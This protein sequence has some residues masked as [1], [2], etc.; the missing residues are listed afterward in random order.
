MRLPGTVSKEDREKWVDTVLDLL[1]L[2]PIENLMVGTPS[3]GGMSFEQKKRVS[4]GV[5]LAANP[6]I[7]FLDE[8]TTGLDSR[9]AQVVMRGIRRVAA[10][11]RSVVCTIHQPSFPIFNMFD[12]LLLLKRGGK[13]VFF[14]QLGENC[15]NLVEFFEAAPEVSPIKPQVNPATWMLDVIGAGT[16][17]ATKNVDY[18]VYYTE[19]ALC[20]ANEVHAIE[21]SS[22]VEGLPAPP[23]VSDGEYVTSF[24]YQFLRLW[25]RQTIAYWRTPGY[26][27]TRVVISLI[28]AGIFGSA[29]PQQNYNNYLNCIARIG[30]IYITTLFVGVIG[31]QTVVPVAFD[32]RPAYY[33]ERQCNMYSAG[34][35]TIVT[36]LVEIPYLIIT[37]L[38]FVLPFF[39]IVGFNHVGNIAEKF[40][41][42]WLFVCLYIATLVTLG[43]MCVAVSP[44][45]QISNVIASVTSVF[46]SMFSG[47]MIQPQNIPQFWTFVYWLNP[48]HYAFE[49]IV[50]TQFKGD[51]TPVT[52]NSAVTVTAE[53]FAGEFFNTWDYEQR[54]YCVLAL[55]VF[56]IA[57][58]FVYCNSLLLY[59]FIYVMFLM[60]SFFVV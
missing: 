59:Y 9:A 47:Y 50:V 54:N 33:R 53:T 16:S 55:F 41:Y 48:L 60:T 36:T 30:V 8:P 38:A 56:I 49:G 20:E 18:H 37:S 52:I 58:R 45:R 2:R 26:N 43:Q 21:L 1:E 28:V 35:Y 24:G 27:L 46:Y 5:E 7:L 19:S 17:V 3:T 14:G 39:Y 44:T 6:A 10:S 40:M 25:Y 51:T 29:Y 23:D 31:M 32:E 13:T 12:A 57:Y 34:I 15:K 42:Y 11:G 22:P 4:I